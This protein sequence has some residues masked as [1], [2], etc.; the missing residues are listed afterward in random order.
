MDRTDGP[1]KTAPALTADMFDTFTGD[2]RWLGFG[3]LG[4]RQ[5]ALTG[6]EEFPP[7]PDVVAAVDGLI[8]AR[9]NELGWTVETL[10]MWANSRLGRWV[11]DAMLAADLDTI[12]EDWEGVRKYVMVPRGGWAL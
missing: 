7:T 11:A 2:P 3:Y 5:Y 9:A 6:D 12:E 1:A 10:F 4:G 8:L